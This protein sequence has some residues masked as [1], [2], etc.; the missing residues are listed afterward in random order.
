MGISEPVR[1]GVVS[2]AVALL[3]LAC[4]GPGASG[5]AKLEVSTPRL[6]PTLSGESV[7][8][9]SVI[10]DHDATVL[11]FW[12]TECPCVRRYQER[13]QAL[14]DTNDPKRVAVLLVASN[15]G[16]DEAH[17]R[18][19]A[20]ERGVK[21]PILRDATGALAAEL[22]AKTTPTAVVLRR[23]GSTAFRGWIDNERLPD[24]AD[25]EPYVERALAG[26]LAGSNDFAARSPIYGCM[27]TRSLATPAA[28]AD[29]F[30]SP[31]Q[32]ETQPPQTCSTCGCGAQHE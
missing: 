22:G 16:E 13:T 30:S 2:V 31:L 28:S 3:A 29:A 7:D 10:R 17:M 24:D 27:I 4:A 23:D 1:A 20:S 25:R 6:L 18:E 15:V 11:V 5:G 21:L 8:L 32:Q 26:L 19:V 14:A 12:S 9:A